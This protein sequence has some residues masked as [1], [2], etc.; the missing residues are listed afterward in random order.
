MSK[1]NSKN[2]RVFPDW[3]GID[4]KSKTIELAICDKLYL[5][6][7]DNKHVWSSDK[8]G[9]WAEQGAPYFK[10]LCDN[11]KYFNY[12]TQISKDFKINDNQIIKI[13]KIHIGRV[14][15]SESRRL[16]DEELDP[17]YLKLAKEDL[18]EHSPEIPFDWEFLKQ[19]VDGEVL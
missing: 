13:D 8:S 2:I 1:T 14:N 16:A 17:H 15:G 9:F 10:H 11:G 6:L 4:T 12:P 3:F 5:T 19:E 18:A 7:T